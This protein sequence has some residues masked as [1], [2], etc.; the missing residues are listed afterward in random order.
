MMSGTRSFLTINK[1]NGDN[2]FLSMDVSYDCYPPR[3]IK[4]LNDHYSTIELA[5]S[6]IKLGSASAID[7]DG[8]PVGKVGDESFYEWTCYADITESAKHC[9][10]LYLYHFDGSKWE[11]N[12]I[13]K[14]S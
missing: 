2:A 5:E 7:N 1:P 8:K 10:C 14:A 4:M 13:Y 11:C 3:M 6:L 12:E 9:D